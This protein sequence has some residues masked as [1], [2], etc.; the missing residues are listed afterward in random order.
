MTTPATVS[1]WLTKAEAAEYMRCDTRTI[2][3][4][5]E[6]GKLTRHRVEGLR[7]VRFARAELDSLVVPERTEG[8]APP[9]DPAPAGTS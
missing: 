1:P 7:S 8:G 6:A 2:D 3:R 4:W 5:T 9:N